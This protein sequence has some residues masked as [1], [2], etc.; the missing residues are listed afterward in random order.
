[1]QNTPSKVGFT[2]FGDNIFKDKIEATFGTNEG[3]LK[4]GEKPG[5]PSIFSIQEE[6]MGNAWFDVDGEYPIVYIVQECLDEE[7][8]FFPWLY[9]EN[10]INCFKIDDKRRT[11]TLGLFKDFVIFVENFKFKIDS[12]IKKETPISFPCGLNG[13]LDFDF[14]SLIVSSAD[15]IDFGFCFNQGTTGNFIF[16]MALVSGPEDCIKFCS[17]IEL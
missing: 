8:R 12:L 1:M 11:D 5:E 9:K 3:K 6:K 2:I 7:D 10:D 4:P 14:F 17:P 16:V 13:L 15:T